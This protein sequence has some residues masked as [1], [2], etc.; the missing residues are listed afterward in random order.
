MAAPEKAG[1]TTTST[2]L[3]DGHLAQKSH[4]ESAHLPVEISARIQA[5]AASFEAHG[6]FQIS[7]GR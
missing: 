5:K 3:L 7:E 1:G 4:R 6:S 2:L